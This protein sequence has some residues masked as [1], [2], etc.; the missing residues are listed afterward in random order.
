MEYGVQPVPEDERIFNRP[1]NKRPISEFFGEVSA[2]QQ[3]IDV[4]EQHKHFVGTYDIDGE[5]ITE[6]R[7]MAW[8]CDP[9]REY[10]CIFCASKPAEQNGFM[11]CRRCN[12]Y[13]GIMPNCN[14]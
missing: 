1:S 12:E 2:T 3:E 11:W 7:L 10:Y 13:K 14:P 6:R 4:Y 9:M 8:A 5:T